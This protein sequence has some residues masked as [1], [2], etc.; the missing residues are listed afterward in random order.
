MAGAK[1]NAVFYSLIETARLHGLDAFA[2]LNYLFKELP[3]VNTLEQTEALLPWNLDAEILR[4]A[5][6]S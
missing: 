6:Y 2:Y 5:A 4:E 1:A 3:M